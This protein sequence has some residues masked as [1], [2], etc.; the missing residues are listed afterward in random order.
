MLA[1]A[2]NTQVKLIYR[3]KILA[4]KREDAEKSLTYSGSVLKN[5]TPYYFC[6]NSSVSQ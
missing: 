3:P 4:E 5:P 6:I 1:V 2:L